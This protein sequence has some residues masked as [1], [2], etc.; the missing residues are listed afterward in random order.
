M[1]TISDT[2]SAKY[3]ESS[4][5]EKIFTCFKKAG[6]ELIEKVLILYYALS[7]DNVPL[8][9]KGVIAGALG[10]FISPIDA[11]PDFLPGG[12]V[13]DVAVLAAAMGTVAV[14]ISQETIDRAKAR[15][16]QFFFVIVMDVGYGIESQINRWR[17]H[18]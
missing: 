11:I 9:A 6:R 16:K 8:W 15:T 10:Y 1:T 4:L 13:D 17:N 14:H 7:D 2:Y 18:G 3:N 12:Y 5:F